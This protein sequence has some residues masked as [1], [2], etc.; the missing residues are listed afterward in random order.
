MFKS[1]QSWKM[2]GLCSI[3]LWLSSWSYLKATHALA[4]FCVLIGGLW[5]LKWMEAFSEK[6]TLFLNNKLATVTIQMWLLTR[7]LRKTH[8]SCSRYKQ[9]EFICILILTIIHFC[10]SFWSL[11]NSSTVRL[12]TGFF[13]VIKLQLGECDLCSFLENN[14]NKNN[15]GTQ[16]EIF[17]QMHL[18]KH[19][20]SLFLK[21]Y[22]KVRGWIHTRTE[23]GSDF[24]FFLRMLAS[25]IKTI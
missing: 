7:W 21:C 13:S 11:R 9:G 5:S 8:L 17:N 19:V 10:P 14:N 4:V 15:N 23:V 25:Y 18:H 6:S 24:L 1:E 16:K 2:P 3:I 12:S 22:G 20:L